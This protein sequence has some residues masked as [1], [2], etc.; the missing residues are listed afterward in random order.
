MAPITQAMCLL[1]PDRDLHHLLWY[2]Y[3]GTNEV[4]AADEATRLALLATPS[5]LAWSGCLAQFLQLI[6]L[7]GV[8]VVLWCCASAVLEMLD[9]L[10]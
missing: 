2:L 5:H 3:D 9:T 6:H 8:A 7:D 4:S 10:W 1:L